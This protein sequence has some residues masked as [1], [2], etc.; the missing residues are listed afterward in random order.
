MFCC[1]LTKLLLLVMAAYF[2]FSSSIF[3]LDVTKLF[4]FVPIDCCS[5]EPS[6]LIVCLCCLPY[7]HLN[8]TRVVNMLRLLNACFAY[9][10]DK[11]YEKYGHF[12]LNLHL[13]LV[14]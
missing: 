5:L 14:L 2:H 3:S 8:C 13:L 6:T 4:V 9:I 11:H 12:V 1:D 7:M 10:C